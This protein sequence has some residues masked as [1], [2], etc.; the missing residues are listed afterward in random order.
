MWRK[1]LLCAEKP[2][3]E[4]LAIIRAKSEKRDYIFAV[5]LIFASCGSLIILLLLILFKVFGQFPKSA[6]LGIVLW[7]IWFYL[8]RLLI[9]KIRLFLFKKDKELLRLIE[10]TEE[11]R[12]IWQEYFP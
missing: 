4:K 5:V 11:A 2:L 8:V 7:L 3:E 12:K 9:R 6:T 1:K 10:L